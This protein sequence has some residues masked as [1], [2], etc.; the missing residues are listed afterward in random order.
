MKKVLASLMVIM[1]LFL[2]LGYAY[3]TQNDKV[4]QVQQSKPDLKQMI[5]RMHTLI[6]SIH[7]RLVDAQARVETAQGRLE[8]IERAISMHLQNMD[9]LSKPPANDTMKWVAD[10][11]I[12][13]NIGQSLA[14]AKSNVLAVIEELEAIIKDAKIDQENIQNYK[15]VLS[16][17]KAELALKAVKSGLI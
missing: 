15:N 5:K 4:D 9:F 1:T 8:Q 12:G 2:G 16:S 10:G 7:S 3:E 13:L 6:E 11:Y 14:D 17:M